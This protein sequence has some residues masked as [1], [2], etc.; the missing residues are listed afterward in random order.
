MQLIS[1]DKVNQPVNAQHNFVDIFKTPTN[2]QALLKATCY[3]CHSNETIYPSYSNYAPISWMVADH[4]KEGRSYLNFSEWGT[5]NK[6]Q[7]NGMLEKSSQTLQNLT[8]PLPSY[9]QQHHK[10][11]LTLE[12]REKLISYFNHILKQTN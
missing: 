7:Q 5:Y 1:I 11:N 4:V 2:V 6:D 9:I 3:D 10:A 8:M 12:Q